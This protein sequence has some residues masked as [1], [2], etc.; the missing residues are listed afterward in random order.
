[1]AQ[2]FVSYAQK[3][4]VEARRILEALEQ[5]GLSVFRE[6]SLAAGVSWADDVRHQIDTAKCVVVL[7]S[8]AAAESQF[9]QQEVAQAIQAWSDGRLVLAV[10]DETEL[11]RGLGDLPATRLGRDAHERDVANL[12]EQVKS[13]AGADLGFAEATPPWMASV[14]K[15]APPEEV[16]A[17]RHDMPPPMATSRGGRFVAVLALLVFGVAG[18]G[19]LSTFMFRSGAP[20]QPPSPGPSEVSLSFGFVAL[21]VIVVA[22]VAAAIGAGVV[23]ALNRRTSRRAEITRLDLARSDAARSQTAPAA[24][25]P[26]TAPRNAPLIFVSYSR[27]DGQTVDQLVQVIEQ[28]GYTVWI[29]RQSTGSQR[30]AAPTVKAIRMSKLVALMCSRHAFESDHVIREVYVAGEC[31]KPFIAFQ[32]DPANFPDDVLYFVSGF[33]RVP[34]TALD[35]QQLRTEIARLVVV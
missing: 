29:D 24:P 8:Q 10:L 35:V 11:P 4:M 13:V 28:A 2:V 6:T 15:P 9:V 17:A 18:G 32:L 31:K 3:D 7:W 20:V 5:A 19:V 16:L 21:L 33:P 14:K 27:Q 34:I 22:A 26:A 1:M 25:A 23:W 30:F 12:V